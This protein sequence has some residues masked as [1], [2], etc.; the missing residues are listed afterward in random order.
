MERS[1]QLLV[2]LVWEDGDLEELFISADNGQ[3]SGVT[4]VY[5]GQG[6]VGALARS[7][8]GF[9]KSISQEEVFKGGSQDDAYAR[10]AFRC[11]DGSGH[12]AVI[13]TLQAGVAYDL[14]PSIVNRVEFEMRFEASALD[15]FCRELQ[16]V[17][18]RARRG[19]VLRGIAA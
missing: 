2:E 14:H 17:A 4:Q 8:Q 9:P 5:F 3:Y 6:D 7:L 13:V 1:P 18:R 19:A 15:E 11:I 10:L 12:A 16:L